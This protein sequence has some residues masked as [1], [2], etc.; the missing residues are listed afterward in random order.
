MRVLRIID[1][2]DLARGGPIE[3][4]RRSA[5]AMAEAGHETELVTLD[6]PDAPC[7]TDFP[8]PVHA[9]GTTERLARLRAPAMTRWITREAHRFDAAVIHGLWN[10]APLA[11]HRGVKR[12][13]LPYV[14]F[15]HGMMDPWFRQAYPAKHWFKQLYWS[16]WQGR[17]LADA[18]R[19]LFTT[20][21]EMQTAQGVFL[22]HGFTSRTVAYGAPDLPDAPDAQQAAFAAA[23]P[24]LDGRP[25]LLYLSRIHE[26]KGCDLL[27]EAFA[28]EVCATGAWPEL[29]LVIAG[30]DA[31]GLG[32]RLRAQARTLGVA[33]RIHWPGMLKGDAKDGAFRGAEA[34]VLPSHQ[35]NFGIV[36]AE[37][38]A[39]RLP[40]LTTTKVNTWREVTGGGAG[41]AEAD[42]AE[43]VGRVLRDWLALDPGARAAMRDAARAT[44]DRHFRI[45]EAGRALTG[46]LEDAIRESGPRAGRTPM[47]APGPAPG[48]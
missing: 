38:L 40:V 27:V 26:K 25:Y 46:A 13:G 33:D 29:Q 9:C 37:A 18:H 8:F 3:G 20:E 34:F 15:T 44:Y 4:L 10:A 5:Q 6:L 30:P 17:V 14:V 2:A 32:D 42:T 22:G 35:E 43:G 39:A 41:F 47:P 36:V 1:S 45:S 31:H 19:V 28:R 24:G 12:A 21:E 16:L 48:A 23:L 7:V 11:G